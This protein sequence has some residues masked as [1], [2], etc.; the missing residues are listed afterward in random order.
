MEQGYVLA[1]TVFSLMFSAMLMDAYRDERS[2]IRIA[3]R[4]DGHLLNYRWMHFQ[5]RIS[6]ITGYELPFADDCPLNTSTKGGMQR[7]MDLLAV[8]RENFGLIINT[9]K[10]V[11]MHQPPRNTAH[12]APQVS[13]DGNH[14]QVVNN[15]TYLGSTLYRSNRSDD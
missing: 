11:V 14:L 12:N 13:V 10:T 15:F 4:T 7:S 3:Y 1:P 6:T 5:S 9:E 8:V 2:D